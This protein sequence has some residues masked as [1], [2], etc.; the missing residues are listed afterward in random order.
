MSRGFDFDSFEMD[1]FRE[2][3]SYDRGRETGAGGAAALCPE[4]VSD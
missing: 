4:Q 1:D 2:S 3:D